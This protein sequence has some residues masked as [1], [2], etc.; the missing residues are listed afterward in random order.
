MS[1]GSS[2][3]QS[4]K[5]TEQHVFRGQEP[6]LLDLYRKSQAIQQE[7]ADSGDI[8]AG[9]IS[10]YQA[11]NERAVDALYDSGQ[12]SQS[13]TSGENQGMQRLAELQGQQFPSGQYSQALNENFNESMAGYDPDSLQAKVIRGDYQDRL[14]HNEANFAGQ[15]YNTQ[16]GMRL[17]AANA[18]IGAGLDA[19]AAQGSLANASMQGVQGLIN[20]GLTPYNAAWA[21]LQ[22]YAQI[23]DAPAVLTNSSSTGNSE[24]YNWSIG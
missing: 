9:I 20:L 6:Y 14:G 16:E 10:P 4:E 8:A 21:P 18:Y 23:V 17:D 11:A 1:G 15:N 7:Q 19:G 22:N 13:V 3:Q 24:G 2:D 12:F 5:K